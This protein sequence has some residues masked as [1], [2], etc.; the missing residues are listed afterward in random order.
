[1]GQKV[2]L[3]AAVLAAL[4]LD[5]AG[6]DPPD[7]TASDRAEASTVHPCLTLVSPSVDAPEPPWVPPTEDP[8][9]GV[10]SPDPPPP[11]DDPKAERDALL[12]RMNDEGVLTDDV[13][14]RLRSRPI[15][16]SPDRD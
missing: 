15:R 7:D 13:V 14:E 3:T 11:P 1:M 12:Q 16:A 2:V 5:A 8:T 4:G 10:P 6:C 9:D